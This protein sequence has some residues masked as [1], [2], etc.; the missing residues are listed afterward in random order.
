MKIYNE[1]LFEQ[2]LNELE[3]IA[4]ENE[5]K[6]LEW[7][8]L[9]KEDGLNPSKEPEYKKMKLSITFSN[10]SR[11]KLLWEGEEILSYPNSS[12]NAHQAK[13]ILRDHIRRGITYAMIERSIQ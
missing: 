7:K 4:N 1:T 13:K 2:L 9:Q 5:K 10:N 6:R 11:L 3:I 8:R 12:N